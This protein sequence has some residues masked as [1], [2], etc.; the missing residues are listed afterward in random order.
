MS[1]QKCAY[2][3]GRLDLKSDYME[4]EHFRDKKDYPNDV[5]I[6][7]NLLPS[8]KHCNGNKS[9]HDV[10]SEPIINPFVDVPREHIF[11]KSYLSLIP[12]DD[13]K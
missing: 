5:L 7:E 10:V 11:L 12:Q 4:V 3:E 2:C 9:S 1:N 13:Y 6:W 8:C